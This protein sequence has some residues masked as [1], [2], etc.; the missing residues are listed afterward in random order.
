M[1]HIRTH[2]D[3]AVVEFLRGVG[4]RTCIPYKDVHIR[5]AVEQRRCFIGLGLTLKVDRLR[6]DYNSMRWK[7]T[8]DLLSE[9]LVIQ[10]QVPEVPTPVTDDNPVLRDIQ[11]IGKIHGTISGTDTDTICLEERLR[12]LHDQHVSAVVIHRVVYISDV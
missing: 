7:V 11:L 6:H 1:R 12:S 5:M 9:I 10:I 4:V 3:I 8:H 2:L